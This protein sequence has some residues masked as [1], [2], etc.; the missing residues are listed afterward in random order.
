MRLSTYLSALRKCDRAA[1]AYYFIAPNVNQRLI[2]RRMVL[3]DK[4]ERKILKEYESCW[5]LIR[6]LS[7]GDIAPISKEKAEEIMRRL[8]K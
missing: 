2:H 1:T 8:L 7:T 5:A 4:L 6:F 3:A